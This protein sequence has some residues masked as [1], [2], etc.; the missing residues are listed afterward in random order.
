MCYAIPAKIMEVKDGDAKV[1][2]GG[3]L[4]KVKKEKSK[5]PD[6]KSNKKSDKKSSKKS[7]KKPGKKSSKKK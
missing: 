5:K 3:I 1:D 4:K 6:K 2:Y 7:D